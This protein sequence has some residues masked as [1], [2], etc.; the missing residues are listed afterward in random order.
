MNEMIPLGAGCMYVHDHI[1]TDR[2]IVGQKQAQ[3]RTEK[4]WQRESQAYTDIY[5][6]SRHM[7]IIVRQLKT[8]NIYIHMG[9]G[10]ATKAFSLIYIYSNSYLY[11]IYIYIYIY[12][13]AY[14]YVYMHVYV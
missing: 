8:Y 1:Q 14:M 7:L 5:I 3:R 4:I 13:Y 11:I 10:G 2:R 12:I 6:Y 9:E